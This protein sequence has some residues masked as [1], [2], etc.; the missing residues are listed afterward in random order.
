MFSPSCAALL[1]KLSRELFKASEV[2]RAILENTHKGVCVWVR[3]EG[4]RAGVG[5]GGAGQEEAG[6]KSTQSKEG[7][8][9][10]NLRS[11]YY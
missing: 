10:A 7:K 11:C 1:I 5:W 2:M 3:A 8:Q 4:T 9:K 6:R